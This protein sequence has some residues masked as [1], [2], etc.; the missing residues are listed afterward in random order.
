MSIIQSSIPRESR[1]HFSIFYFVSNKSERLKNG[2]YCTYDK[3]EFT[4]SEHNSR[5]SKKQYMSAVCVENIDLSLSF[6]TLK[7]IYIDRFINFHR[8]YVAHKITNVSGYWT[9]EHAID[10]RKS[11]WCQAH[12]NTNLNEVIEL[13][14][15][16]K[17]YCGLEEKRKNTK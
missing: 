14:W 12:P 16:E 9:F 1:M 15:Q 7:Y 13:N 2:T 10:V 5:Q 11:S 17:K 4:K 8:K 3:I 6:I